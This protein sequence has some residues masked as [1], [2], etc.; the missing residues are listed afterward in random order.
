MNLLD[1]IQET[2]EAKRQFKQI[3]PIVPIREWIEDSYY[4]GELQ[5]YPYWKKVIIDFYEGDFLEIILSG[6]IGVGK[7]WCGLLIFLRE[8]YILSCY[9]NVPMKFR[10]DSTSKILFFYLSVTIKQAEGTGFGKLRRIIDGSPYFQNEFKR[11]KNKNSIIEFLQENI[12]I[13]SGSNASD[14]I[15]ADLHS[16][17]LDESNFLKKGGGLEGSF[18][19]AINIYRESTNRRKARFMKSGTQSGVAIITSSSTT[20][21]SFTASRIEAAKNNSRVKVVIARLWEVLPDEYSDETFWVFKGTDKIDPFIYDKDHS[22]MVELYWKYY[23]KGQTIDSYDIPPEKDL[24][25]EIP[26]DFYDSFMI[27]VIGSLQEIAGVSLGAIGKFFS[28]EKV[29]N[30]NIKEE[31]QPVFTKPEIQ[32]STADDK[33]VNE[34]LIPNL[35]IPGNFNYH[36][37]IDQSLS[38]D[39]TGM[40]M[41][42]L[43]FL[44]YDMADYIA[45]EDFAICINPPIRP[46]QIDIRKLRQFIFYLRDVLKFNIVSVSYDVFASAE[47]I[48]ELNKKH[49][50]AFRLSVDRND[51][52]YL[53]YTSLMS[54]NRLKIYHHPVAKKELFNLYHNIEK[55]KI[56][57]PKKFP[58]GKKGSKD[59][60][61][62]KVGSVWGAILYEFGDDKSTVF[63]TEYIKYYITKKL[64]KESKELNSLA[65]DHPDLLNVDKI[66]PVKMMSLRRNPKYK[67]YFIN[68]KK[69]YFGMNKR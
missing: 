66:D 38:G 26:V 3:K 68:N 35:L 51:S 67:K 17:M 32:C 49:I 21:T 69:N 55:R 9:E 54:A 53:H 59:T 18:S 31:F 57:H 22:D 13:A 2:K 44:S 41:S 29:Y 7:S 14:F 39:S 58:D 25:E 40:G 28:S 45:V 24:F 27:D 30:D 56:D 4:I 52:E 10:L 5:L 16:V 50:K 47:A 63:D 15:G 34:Y 48:Q 20:M 64:K 62:A 33:K 6:A 61:D 12:E 36:I 8:V 1:A 23:F 60:I 43:E 42:H 19:K 46:A 65:G 37:H 11:N